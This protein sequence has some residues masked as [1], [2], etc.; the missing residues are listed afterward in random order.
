LL[1][2]STVTN[3]ASNAAFPKSLL[4]RFK[5]EDVLPQLVL[6]LQFPAP[7][8]RLGVISHRNFAL[9]KWSHIAM[10]LTPKLSTKPF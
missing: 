10:L 5:E 2:P 7:V 8:S 1:V 9:Q 3:P 6:C 4:D